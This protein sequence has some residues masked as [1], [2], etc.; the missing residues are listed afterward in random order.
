M[1]IKIWHK[2]KTLYLHLIFIN[3]NL[4][5]LETNVDLKFLRLQIPFEQKEKL[6]LSVKLE[7]TINSY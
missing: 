7:M 3:K 4:K 2:N 1:P 6:P 5:N